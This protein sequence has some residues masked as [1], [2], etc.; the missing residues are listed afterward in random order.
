MTV[1]GPRI[2]AHMAQME[3]RPQPVEP[4]PQPAETRPQPAET[5]PEWMSIHE[6][7]TLMGVSSATLRRWSDAG[8]IQTFTTPGGHRR[9]SRSAVARMLP[10]SAT[11][12]SPEARRREVSRAVGEVSWFPNLDPVAQRQMRR[13]AR[14]IS[15]ALVAY[16]DAGAAD[17][18]AASLAEAESCAAACGELAAGRGVGL[19]ETVEAFLTFRASYLRVLI[20]AGSEHVNGGGARASAASVEAATDAFDRLVCRAMRA[21]EGVSGGS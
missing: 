20:D 5:R 13:H 17:E 3:P 10:S 16:T 21:H 9:F 2:E 1:H 11:G 19:R 6:A 4:R 7:S 15:T 8:S 14:R 18:R 12:S